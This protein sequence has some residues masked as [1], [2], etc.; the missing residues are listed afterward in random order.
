MVEGHG[1]SVLADDLGAED[2]FGLSPG[3]IQKIR[4]FFMPWLLRKPIVGGARRAGFGSYAMPI[5]F[6]D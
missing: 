4:A 3:D 5:L 6:S 2:P 1:R